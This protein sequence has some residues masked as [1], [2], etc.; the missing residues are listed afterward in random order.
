MRRPGPVGRDD[1]CS[2][3]G[4]VFLAGT[5][6]GTDLDVVAF[7]AETVD[8][9]VGYAVGNR[10]DVFIAIVGYTERGGVHIALSTQLE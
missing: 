8:N 6:R 2:G 3:E 1:V 7:F 4:R 9:L 5:L 10:D